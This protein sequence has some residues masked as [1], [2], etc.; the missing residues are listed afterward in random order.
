MLE[1]SFLYGQT[2][3]ATEIQQQNAMRIQ[4]G[5]AVPPNHTLSSIS[6]IVFWI[7]EDHVKLRFNKFLTIL[8]LEWSSLKIRSS[9]PL[10]L[11]L[12]PKAQ[13]SSLSLQYQFVAP[14]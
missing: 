2:V 10:D 1:R 12:R 11:R 6:V 7:Q 8:Y 5:Q 13:Q 14:P 4:I 9:H 3:T